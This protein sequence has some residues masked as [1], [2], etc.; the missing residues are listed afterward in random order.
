[1][2]KTATGDVLRKK[3]FFKISQNSQEITVPEETPVNF[4]KLLRI[5][6]LQNNLGGLLLKCGYCNNKARDIY[7]ICCRELDAILIASAKIP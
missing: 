5:P 6:F 2:P 4:A 1:M 7:C 3:V